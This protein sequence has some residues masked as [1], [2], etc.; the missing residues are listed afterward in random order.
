MAE[1]KGK[2]C[3]RSDDYGNC[4][5]NQY[6]DY[7]GGYYTD[8]ELCEHCIN[9]KDCHYIEAKKEYNYIMPFGKYKGKTLKHIY[10]VNADYIKWLYNKN[11][12][13]GYLKECI[14]TIYKERLT[15]C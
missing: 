7:D 3:L 15:K 2:T 12:T 9:T 6:G 4:T 14:D 13:R 5:Y 11:I 10:N 1:D 8:Y